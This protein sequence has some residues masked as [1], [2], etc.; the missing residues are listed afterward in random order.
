VGATIVLAAAALHRA[1]PAPVRPLSVEELLVL[2][3]RERA[4]ALPP[5]DVLILGDSSA[6]MDV[7][8]VALG[9]DLGHAHVESLA[10][11]AWVG[12]A[13]YAHI[14][15]QVLATQRPARI[16][17]LMNGTGLQ[18]E[19]AIY[20][21]TGYEAMVLS[22]LPGP[23]YARRQQLAADV[24]DG[25]FL[26]SMQSV[27]DFPLPGSYGRTYGTPDDLVTYIRQHQGG[28]V[29]PNHYSGKRQEYV[30]RLSEATASRLATLREALALA[31]PSRVSFGITPVPDNEV[32]A[33]TAESRAAVLAGVGRALDLPDDALLDLPLSMFD[34]DFATSSHL[35]GAARRVFTELVARAVAR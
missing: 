24:R 13:G 21:G 11:L 32:G 33:R 14:L 6:L 8:P 15:R 2:A 27:V 19:E 1:H 4:G 12:P 16:V 23:G 29:D 18:Q 20:A 3:Q 25:L 22:D 10:T 26:E 34:A 31:A 35:G 28:L 9:E 30:F 7:D 17:I 5:T